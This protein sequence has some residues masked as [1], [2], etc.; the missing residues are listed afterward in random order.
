MVEP[1]VEPDAE[2]VHPLRRRTWR[3][4]LLAD[5]ALEPELVDRL[6]NDA[7]AVVD[8]GE[9][10]KLGDRCTVV[11]IEHQNE[12]YVLK[13]FNRRDPVHS[14]LHWPLRS[15]AR[16]CWINAR[17]LLAA[18]LN[19]P[20]PL[21]CVEARFGPLRDRSFALSAFV[22]GETLIDVVCNDPPDDRLNRLAE[23]FA[24]MWRELDRLRLGHRDMK[25]TN[26][27]VDKEDRLWMVDLDA[28]RRYPPGFLF[29]RRRAKDLRRF[30]K[31]WRDQP[32]AAQVFR[33]RIDT[34]ARL[35]SG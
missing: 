24:H 35:A 34:H 22:E 32:E 4:V 21:A 25:A 7:D 23:Q 26:F 30:M 17:R 3:R 29:A 15:R 6:W 14:V 16:W 8:A 1:A 12:R 10:I 31:N 33:A 19:T 11:T 2:S 20:R 9:V 13:R 28:M 18:G 5:R 27:I